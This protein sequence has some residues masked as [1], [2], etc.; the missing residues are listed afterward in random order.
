VVFRVEIAMKS[1]KCSKCDRP[2]L[3]HVTE[4]DYSDDESPNKTIHDIHLCLFHAVDAGLVAGVSKEALEEIE[5][6]GA[7]L[8]AGVPIASSATKKKRAATGKQLACPICGTT[9]SD[10]EQ[11]GLMGCPHDME[12]FESKLTAVV[13]GLQEGRLQHV[14]KIPLRSGASAAGLQAQ[15]NRLRESLSAAVAKEQFELA[16]QLRDELKALEARAVQP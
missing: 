11:S 9:W 10:F 12:I 13:K 8:I 3:I 5:S 1:T 2:A 15:I 16:A 14:G 6:E 4:I 7:T